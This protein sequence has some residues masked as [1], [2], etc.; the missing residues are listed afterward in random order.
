MTQIFVKGNVKVNLLPRCIINMPKVSARKLAQLMTY[1]VEREQLYVPR[2]S[3]D[4]A[5][6]IH[7]ELFSRESGRV[8]VGGGHSAYW[9]REI[10][11]GPHQEYGTVNHGPQPFVRPAAEDTAYHAATVLGAN[12]EGELLS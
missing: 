2:K 7:G 1:C 9:G 10:D 12:I 11:Y 5:D 8:T 4:L 6:T 3:G